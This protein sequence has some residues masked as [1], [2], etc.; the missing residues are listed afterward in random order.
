MGTA[1][2]RD[3]KLVGG[4]D[5]LKGVDVKKLNTMEQRD[6]LEALQRNEDGQKLTMDNISALMKARAKGRK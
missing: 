1:F 5:T 6:A 3:G 4:A 2:I